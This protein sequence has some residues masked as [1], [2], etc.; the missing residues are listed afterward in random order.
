VNGSPK[1]I[2]K[3]KKAKR[4]ILVTNKQTVAEI[5]VIHAEKHKIAVVFDVN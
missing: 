4:V 3:I 5:R 2:T 1:D